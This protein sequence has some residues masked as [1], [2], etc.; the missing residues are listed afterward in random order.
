MKNP[1]LHDFRTSNQFKGKPSDS[2][3]DLQK[4]KLLTNFVGNLTSS[5]V[6][7]TKLTLNTL[8]ITSP[9]NEVRLISKFV[10]SFS[11]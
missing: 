4:L 5:P 11:L 6:G 3:K 1:T 8:L 2:F 10:R 7:V 9:R